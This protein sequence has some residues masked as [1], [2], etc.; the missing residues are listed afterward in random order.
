MRLMR[1]FQLVYVRFVNSPMAVLVF[2]ADRVTQRTTA[3]GCLS[4]L[5]CQ[6]A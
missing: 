6:L 3:A 4:K 1:V 2:A 5:L